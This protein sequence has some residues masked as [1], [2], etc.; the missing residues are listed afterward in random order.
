MPQRRHPIRTLL[1]T[2]AFSLLA[3]VSA[4]A[5]P[6]PTYV[7]NS[8]VGFAID[9]PPSWTITTYDGQNRIDVEDDE[10]ILTVDAIELTLLPSEDP[11]IILDFILDGLLDTFD[12]LDGDLMPGQTLAGLD[13]LRIDFEGEIDGVTVYGTLI[14]TFDDV[15][16]YYLMFAVDADLYDDYEDTLLAMV[17]SFRFDW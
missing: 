7:V 17:D 10:A 12:T 14:F 4:Q 16:V 6:M 1:L 15:Y 5:L 3:V 11:I 13:A 9:Y 2:L 8:E